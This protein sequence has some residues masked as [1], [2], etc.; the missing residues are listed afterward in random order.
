MPR[1]P[2]TAEK[3]SV[4]RF[5][6]E[7][8]MLMV[9]DAT[10]GLPAANAPINFDQG[11]FITQGLGP[12]GEMVEYYNFDVQSTTPAPIYALFH[13]GSPVSGQL[14]IIDKI[15][16]EA[17]Y[18]DFWQVHKVTVP[19]GY[20]ANTITSRQGIIDR[21]FTMEATSMIV[22][23][24]V[25]PDGSTATKRH[26]GGSSALM[27]GWYKDK[28]VYYFTFEEKALSATS[29]SLVPLSP[30]YVTFNE[31]PP[32]GG[33][34]TGFVVESGTMKTHNVIATL[35]ANGSY[36]P[37][38]SVNVYDNADFATV[39]NLSTAQAATILAMGVANVNCPV[40][41]VQ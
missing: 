2:D 41:S 23:C 16:G 19:E 39:M 8:G 4:D 14:N 11:P 25:V 30:I 24:P 5:S 1:D 28:V 31:N 9:R 7:A 32:S 37:L 27:R 29:A 15:P 17:G 35:P 12:G 33:P 36:S 40:V 21:G 18:N 10:N 38:W 6:A 22:N 26:G 34:A 3:V 20:V 13:D